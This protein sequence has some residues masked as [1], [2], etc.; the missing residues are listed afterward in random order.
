MFRNVF[1]PISQSITAM[2]KAAIHGVRL[3][4]ISGIDHIGSDLR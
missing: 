4:V 3:G 1:R 2:G